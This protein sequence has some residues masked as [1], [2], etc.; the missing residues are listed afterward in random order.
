M[1]G[2]DTYILDLGQNRWGEEEAL[3]HLM[4]ACQPHHRPL[5]YH[6]GRRLEL[7]V[8]NTRLDQWEFS[9]CWS[10]Q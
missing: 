4:G 3:V 10:Q 7:V 8:C 2:G 1:K 9:E 5:V 6:L